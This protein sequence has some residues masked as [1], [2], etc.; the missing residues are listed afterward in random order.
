MDSTY[1]IVVAT[2]II[3]SAISFVLWMAVRRPIDQLSTE[4][5][6]L[7]RDM[8]QLAE[9][10]V[11]SI[12]IKQAEHDRE[13]AQAPKRY[14]EADKCRELHRELAASQAEFRSAVVDLAHVQEA[15]KTTANF[16]REVNQRVIGAM[17]DIASIKSLE[18]RVER[19]E[20]R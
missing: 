10:R 12:E 4:N 3:Q 11:S 2:T 13:L 18:S 16:V 7:R 6:D 20:D 14:T 8:R 1:I 15:V 9:Q 17:T 5:A 19:L